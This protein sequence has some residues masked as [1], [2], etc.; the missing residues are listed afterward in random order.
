MHQ[1]VLDFWFIEL[2]PNQWWV[3]D[4]ELDALIERR[5][6]DLHQ[7]AAAGKLVDWRDN[8]Q[9]SLAE[10]IVL[11]Q[12]SRNIY[13]DKAD[14]FAHDAL[15]LALAQLA[16]AKG[17]DLKLN[18][19]ERSFLYLPYMHSESAAVHSTAVELYQTLGLANNL[20]FELK[21]KAI[22]DRFG[23]YPHRN[24]ILGRVSTDEEQEFLKQPNSGF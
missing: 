22:I 15:A 4:L 14:S 17:F 8:P 21:H 7:Q 19:T 2:E 12:F 18:D 20:E 3:K 1:Q 6:G 13:R 10:I 16:V 24:T 23:R 5:F 9:A 11:D